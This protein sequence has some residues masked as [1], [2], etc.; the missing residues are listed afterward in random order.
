MTAASDTFAHER[1]RLLALAYRMLGSVAEAEDIVQDAFTRIADVDPATIRSAPALL[2]TVVTRLSIN[3]LNSARHRREQYVGPWLP[4]PIATQ[5]EIDPASVSIAFMVLLEA[6][7]PSERAAFLLHKVFDYSH[8]EI[9]AALGVEVATSR[10]LVHRAKQHLEQKKPRFE[11]RPEVH[12]RLFMAF[13][14]ACR[15]GDLDALKSLLADDVVCTADHGGK[16]SAARK[17]VVGPDH[18]ARL[19]LGLIA[20]LDPYGAR[21]EVAEVN[22]FPAALAILGNALISVVTFATDGD[23]ICEIDIVRNPDKLA[24]LASTLG[25]T[26]MIEPRYE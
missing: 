22:G 10:Q 23:H 3:A 25:Y 19:I 18:V 11:A 9:A 26:T 12:A 15:T 24:T 16:A 17:P 20:R 6:L 5:A 14:E 21:M 4:E 13:G 7:T 8:E 1:P 2:T